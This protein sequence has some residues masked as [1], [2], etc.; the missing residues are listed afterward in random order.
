MGAERPA[1]LVDDETYIPVSDV[2][3]DFGEHFFAQ[4]GWRPSPASSGSSSSSAVCIAGSGGADRGADRSS[5]PDSVHRLNYSDHAAETGQAVPD[6]PI[7]FTKS[8]YTFVG[9]NDDVRIPRGATKTDWEVELGVVIGPRCSYLGDDQ[10][11]RD[12]IAGLFVVNDVSERAFQSERA[13][14]G[15]RS[16]RRSPS[17]RSDLGSRL[18]T[19]LLT[20][21]RCACGSTSTA[22]DAR[23]GRPPR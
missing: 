15:P 9:P 6:E 4:G 16:S 7:L 2:V 21:P 19:R 17:T 1:V 11:A 10:E 8:P 20:S 13:A 3:T 22:S 23:T 18:P 12:G 5:A 14:S